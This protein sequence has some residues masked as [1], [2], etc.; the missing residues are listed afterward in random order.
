MVKRKGL[1]KV[2]NLSLILQAMLRRC[3]G[4]AL[5]RAAVQAYQASRG[6]ADTG[7]VGPLTRAE[8]NKGTLVSAAAGGKPNLTDE[9]VTSILGVL[10]SFNADQATVDRVRA[11]LGK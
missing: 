1:A 10:Q 8:L 4:W 7:F 9:Q 3:S 5:T 6:I 2:S 11:A